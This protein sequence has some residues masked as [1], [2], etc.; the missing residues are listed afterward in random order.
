M[1]TRRCRRLWRQRPGQV[2]SGRC[3]RAHRAHARACALHARLQVA[4]SHAGGKSPPSLRTAS[5]S[6]YKHVDVSFFLL[7]ISLV[8]SLSHLFDL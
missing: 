3:R 6:L 1:A 8:I 2:R 4:R 5:R 7:S